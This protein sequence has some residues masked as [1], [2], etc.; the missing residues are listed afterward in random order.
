MAEAKKITAV[1][2]KKLLYGETS[3]I[4]ADLTGQALYTLLQGD[5]LKEVK[6][7]HGDT[8]TLEEAEASRTNYK[9]QLTGQTYRSEKEMGDVTVN[10][11]IGE[12]DY[13]TKKDLMGGDVINT[14]KGWKRARGKVNI[15]KLIVALTEDDQYCVIPRADIGAREATTDKAIGLPVSAVELEPKDSAIAPEYWFD[16]EEVKAGM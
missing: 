16:S 1:N 13:P 11:T 3:G 2:I 6:N 10:F 15:E 9:N 7:I 12:Y 8:W 5:T 4:S 14:D